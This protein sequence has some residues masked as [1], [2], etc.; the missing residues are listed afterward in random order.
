MLSCVLAS[1]MDTLHSSSSE[2]LFYL[3]PGCNRYSNKLDIVYP[4]STLLP[5][6]EIDSMTDYANEVLSMLPVSVDNEE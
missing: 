2:F 4:I 6:D 5:E 1:T 3:P